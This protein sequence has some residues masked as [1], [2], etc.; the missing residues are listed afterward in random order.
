[1]VASI[2]ADETCQQILGQG[3]QTEVSVFR[4]FN[5]DGTVL[6]KAR[7]DIVPAGNVLADVKTTIDAS[8]EAFAK[9][10][11]PVEQGGQGYATQSAYYL[12]CWNDS[13][14]K[15]S[16]M[17]ECFVF[18]VVEKTPPYLVAAYNVEPRAIAKGRGW[19]T[20]ALRTYINCA[21]SGHFPGYAKGIQNI[22]LPEWYY[23]K[24][25][26]SYF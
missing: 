17:K 9:A 4:N 12:D 21:N 20:E 25:T 18:I 8:P 2:A 22:D 3:C 19:N 5:Y 15:A 6:R 24:L 23:K 16:D 7:L 14:E 1:M 11:L 10:L 26:P 13:C